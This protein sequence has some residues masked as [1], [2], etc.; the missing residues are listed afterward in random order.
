MWNTLAEKFIEETHS[1][2]RRAIARAVVGYCDGLSI[3]TFVGE[4]LGRIADRARGKR[5][6]YWD[7]IFI[8]DCTIPEAQGKTYSEIVESPTFGLDFKMAE[9]SQSS[10]AMRQLLEFLRGQQHHSFWPK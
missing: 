2:S 8:P 7:T 4:T 10:K 1:S 3:K 5:E 9:L 6:F